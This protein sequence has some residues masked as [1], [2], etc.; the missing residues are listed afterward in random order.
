MENLTKARG[1]T[2]SSSWEGHFS[3][4][5]HPVSVCGAG[6][7]E[8]SSVLSASCVK[9]GKT[10]RVAGLHFPV[11]FMLFLANK[12]WTEVTCMIRFWAEALRAW[13]ITQSFFPPSLSVNCHSRTLGRD[14]ETGILEWGWCMVVPCHSPN[15]T[16]GTGNGSEQWISAVLSHQDLG[17]CLLLPHNQE[18]ADWYNHQAQSTFFSLPPPRRAHSGR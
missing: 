6:H 1:G 7:Q 11:Y 10:K 8:T 5:S 12:M 16:L 13:T 18:H 4:D 14:F 3:S 9:Y 17:G 2:A 15:P